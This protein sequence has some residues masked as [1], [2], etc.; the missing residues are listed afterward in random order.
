MSKISLKLTPGSAPPMA[1]R[2]PVFSD[3]LGIRDPSSGAEW[4]VPSLY[5]DPPPPGCPILP[6]AAERAQSEAL[7]SFTPLLL[8]QTRAPRQLG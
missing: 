8:E 1:I 6:D 4:T 2:P 7:V 3:E 5:R